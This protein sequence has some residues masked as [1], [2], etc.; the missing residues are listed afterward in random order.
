L[1]THYLFSRV[2]R[3]ISEDFC[4]LPDPEKK[5]KRGK[6][7]KKKML[8]AFLICFAV[9]PFTAAHAA[10]WYVDNTAT[11]T[12][13]GT[14]W[15]NA[16]KS[17]SAIAWSSIKPGDTIYISGGTTSKIYKE[18][19]NPATSGT[20]SSPI[21][22]KPGQ[23][24][25]HNGVVTITAAAGASSGGIRLTKNNIDING[26]VGG[27][28]NIRVTG[29]TQNGVY[30]T[31]YGLSLQYLEIDN[32]GNSSASSA[33]GNGIRHYV[34]SSWD[35]KPNVLDVGYCKIHNNW[36]DQIALKGSNGAAMFGRF[37]VHHNEIYELQ[38][39]GLE[40]DMRGLDFYNN[41]MHT[42]ATGKG[43][44][45]S[46]G[47]QT[48]AGYHR[49]YNNTF[50]NFSHPTKT[51]VNSYMLI[52]TFANNIA[53]AEDY[54]YVYNNLI[55]DTTPKA[56]LKKDAYLRGIEFTFGPSSITTGTSH[57][58]IANNTVVGTPYSGLNVWP[59]DGK[60]IA[61]WK[62]YNNIVYNC[63]RLGSGGVAMDI[64]YAGS[65][66]IGSEGDGKQVQ[67]DY[68]YVHQGSE[69]VQAIRVKGTRYTT[70][71][72]AMSAAGINKHLTTANVAPNLTSTYRSQSTSPGVNKAYKFTQFGSDIDA[73]NRPQG[74]AWDLGAS[75]YKTT[76]TAS[77]Q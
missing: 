59:K 76:S 32:N 48:S 23:T 77:V 65:W 63:Y 55:Y 64:G 72:A 16:W 62:I 17:F 11:G 60:T 18:V 5:E 28:C 66:T 51:G 38:D 43:V 37:K 61:D 25:P 45:H 46:D 19:L 34:P 56:S 58:V 70:Y 54:I 69:G 7:M 12:G 44:G 15:T 73:V 6:I 14:S 50:Y 40:D 42:F 35:S 22:I 10:T 8:F 41:K 29:C 30:A 13:N 26:N 53:Q 57:V 52:S 67:L 24:S 1:I 2:N 47:I 49:I 36:Q 9:L 68:N 3:E 27:K 74:T 75:E 20:D 4:A 21:Y 33:D 31:G 71:A 39:D